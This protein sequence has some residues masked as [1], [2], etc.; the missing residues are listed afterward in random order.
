MREMEARSG[1]GNR[2]VRETVW[3]FVAVGAG[4]WE[5]SE[6]LEGEENVRVKRGG[7]SVKVYAPSEP[8]KPNSSYL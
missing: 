7:G 8:K 3:F 2:M 6:I 4:E 1:H 5:K